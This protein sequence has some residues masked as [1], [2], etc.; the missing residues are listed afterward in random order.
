MWEGVLTLKSF[1]E[2]EVYKHFN[3][4]DP[5]YLSHYMYLPLIARKLNDYNY[6]KFFENKSLLGAVN[7]NAS[8]LLVFPKVYCR[9][10]NGDFYDKDMHQ[11]S[12]AEAV[13]ICVN[14]NVLIIKDSVDSA[15]GK[16]VSKINLDELSTEGRKVAVEKEF[17]ERKRDFVVQECVKQSLVMAKFNEKYINTFRISTLYLNGNVTLCNIVLRYGKPHMMLDNWGVGGILCGV[18]ADGKLHHTGWDIQLNPF[19]ECN[20]IALE[21]VKFDFIPDVVSKVLKAHKD[22]FPLC[23]FIGW[24]ICIGEKGEP[25][26]IE[27]NSSQP[28]IFGEQICNG[29]MFGDRT[30]EVIDYI[31]NKPFVYNR[32]LLRY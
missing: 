6:T 24:D 29:P 31:K 30:Q 17:F 10:I 5:R 3:G 13:E 8:C 1:K 11:I 14:Q 21:S 15:G 19:T 26:V 2:L 28:G 7:T 27:I 25:V 9:R 23:K 32:A 22:N 4:F 18:A 16:S 12:K 20:G